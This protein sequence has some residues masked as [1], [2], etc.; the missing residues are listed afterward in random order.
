MEASIKSA[1]SKYTERVRV[2]CRDAAAKIA[3]QFLQRRVEP[4]ESPGLRA[5]GQYLFP[6]N[7]DHDGDLG[8]QFGIF[9]T[10]AALEV[11]AT[12]SP[13]TY[14]SQ[15]LSS[16][17]ILP[18][19]NRDFN[20]EI[21]VPIHRYFIDKGDLSVI[22]KLC[23]LL[24]AINAIKD[25]SELSQSLNCS[26]DDL[27]ECIISMRVPERGWPAYY[28]KDDDFDHSTVHA[29]STALFSLGN[30]HVTLDG[31]QLRSCAEAIRWLNTEKL[32]RQSIATVS[33]TLMAILKLESRLREAET[34]RAAREVRERCER[35]LV[36][37]M[38]VSAPSEVRRSLEGTEY[39]VAP[40]AGQPEHGSRFDFLVYLPHCLVALACLRNIRLLRLGRAR[41]F[42]IAVVRIISADVIDQG[43]FVAAGRT[44]VSTVEHMWLHRLMS[45]VERG[46]TFGF[47]WRHLLIDRFA[48]IRYRWIKVPAVIFASLGLLAAGSLATGLTQLAVQAVA[49]LVATIVAT[50]AV[51][52]IVEDL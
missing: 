7:R 2:D 27:V 26:A 12:Q 42:T 10:A 4:P 43:Y 5:W 52:L 21:I 32:E 16:C 28:A 38:A 8:M 19:C 33:I 25:D 23:A 46:G 24:D 40:A 44:L 45:E 18:P 47:K 39:R 31:D 14:K 49:T 9:G 20:H 35:S 37:W 1:K 6:I 22:F 50:L 13:A 34:S 48:R 51:W 3:D 41:R 29:T 30:E 36:D 15:L 11:L 17:P